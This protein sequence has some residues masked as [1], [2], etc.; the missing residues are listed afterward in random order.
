MSDHNHNTDFNK[1]AID[2]ET[3]Y[4]AA[5]LFKVFG[6]PTRIRILFTLSRNELCVQDIADSLSMTQSAI[7]HQLRILK[8]AALV[9]FRRDGK[10]IYYSLADDHI[11]TIMHQ[12]IE[13][14]CE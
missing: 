10:T 14:V 7:S 3:L 12:G 13:H 6:D 2:I 9:K 4:R 8:Q 5:E 1:E 11:E